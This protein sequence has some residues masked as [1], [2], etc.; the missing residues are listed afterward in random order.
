MTPGAPIPCF[1]A[2]C[3]VYRIGGDSSRTF[4]ECRP[5]RK[6]TAVQ[7]EGSLTRERGHNAAVCHSTT[8][9]EMLQSM[10]WLRPCLVLLLS[11]VFTP[12][13]LVA[14]DPAWT[15]PATPFRIIGNV[16][17]VGS[18]DLASYLIVTPQGNILINSN[19]ASSPAQIRKSVEALG[20][21]FSD[22]KILLISHGHFDHA[23]GSAMLKQM[24]GAQYM[25]MDRDVSIVE[26][27]GRSD[28]S[29]D[30]DAQYHFPPTKVDRV[31]HDGDEVKLEST[32][33]VAHRTAG[34]T[35]GCTTWTLRVID[36]GRP[37]N[38]VIVGSTS[39]LDSYRLVGRESYPGIAADYAQTF[40]TLKGLPCDVFLAAHGSMFGLK[41]K[42]AKQQAGGANP[43]I[44]PSGYRAA[45]DASE[46]A[47]EAK[48][49]TQEAAAR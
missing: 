18:Q 31:L 23:S 26:D 6:E 34:H 11:V 20:F 41:E 15:T 39:V 4:R 40:R 7:A 27:G 16:Y 9:C 29:L 42:Q 36:Q 14:A 13:L 22:T 37:Y 1:Y 45:V 12:G 17:Y 2:L 25:V 28:F 48:L 47:F 8:A 49:K 3:I 33:L 46:Q 43:F 30:G 5:R 44:D 10:R 35:R 21:R 24:T 32:V 38:V 19:L